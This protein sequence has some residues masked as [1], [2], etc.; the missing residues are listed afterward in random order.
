MKRYLNTDPA[1]ENKGV[2]GKI[3]GEYIEEE[4]EICTV[5][6]LNISTDEL[7]EKYGKEKGNYV[8]IFSDPFYLLDSSSFLYFA[9]VI[10]GEIEDTIL[11]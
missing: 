9:K 6:R 10:A 1:V 8:T 2:W 7:S 4:N 11:C 3:G 5:C